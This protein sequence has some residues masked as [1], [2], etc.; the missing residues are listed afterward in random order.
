VPLAFVGATVAVKVTLVPTAA[1]LALEA[2][3]VVVISGLPEVEHVE[4]AGK[5]NFEMKAL[6]GDMAAL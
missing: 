6:P 1:G 4:V 5:L 2:R 3:V